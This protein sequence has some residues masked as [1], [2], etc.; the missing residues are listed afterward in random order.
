MQLVASYVEQEDTDSLF[1][2]AVTKTSKTELQSNECYTALTVEHVPVKFKVDTGAQVN[3]LS[4]QMY[5]SLNTQA[6]LERSDTK[7][8][9]HS[10]DELCVK[11]KSHLEC[12]GRTVEF[13]IVDTQ[14]API[15]GLNDS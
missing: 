6:K 3:I 9:T 14:Q 10:N 12:E 5:T 2:G 8:T 7:L 13:Y 15:L 1:I 11:E 4:L